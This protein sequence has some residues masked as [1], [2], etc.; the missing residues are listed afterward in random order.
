M[1]F[2]VRLR[3]RENP[4]GSYPAFSPLPSTRSCQ[5]SVVGC[6]LNQTWPS[7]RKDDLTPWK[8][9]T[10][11][12]AFFTDNCLL[13]TPHAGRFIF[14][15]TFRYP[16]FAP[17]V[18]SFSRGMPP[19]GVRTFLWRETFQPAI[20][21]H[22]SDPIIEEGR[23]PAPSKSRAVCFRRYG[24]R[25]IASTLSKPVRFAHFSDE[26][27]KICVSLSVR[28]PRGFRGVSEG[29]ISCAAWEN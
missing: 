2:F 16:G 15:D 5:F 11:V 4:V 1:G 10:L 3:L 8:T 22:I 27:G 9:L 7:V 25:F 29:K 14:C 20:A 26:T 28:F 12:S 17:Q 18:P 19:S 21:C 6:Q 24:R 23:D 13:T